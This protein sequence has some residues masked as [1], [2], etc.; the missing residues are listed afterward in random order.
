MIVTFED[1]MFIHIATRG[2]CNH[3]FSLWSFRLL[4]HQNVSF[5]GSLHGFYFTVM[6]V[7]L[8]KVVY[9]FTAPHTGQPISLISGGSCHDFCPRVYCTLYSISSLLLPVSN[10]CIKH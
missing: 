1:Y 9:I 4:F 5:V 6:Y 2:H 7:R 8:M 10:Y 3:I